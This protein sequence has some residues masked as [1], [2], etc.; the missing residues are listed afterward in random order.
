MPPGM[1]TVVVPPGM[2]TVVMPPG[3]TT[4]PVTMPPGTSATTTPFIDA[5]APVVFSPGNTASGGYGRLA[6]QEDGKQA[7]I[8]V[9][10]DT[11]IVMQLGDSISN[12]VL[13]YVVFSA[14][15]TTLV[16]SAGEAATG[17]RRHDFGV[18]SRLFILDDAPLA[19][20]YDGASVGFTSVG[21][22]YSVSG[23]GL[24]TGQQTY[25]GRLWFSR[26]DGNPLPP[27]LH[28]NLTLTVDNF[29]AATPIL[30]IT[31]FS[32]TNGGFSASNIPIDTASGIFIS[33]DGSTVTF[34]AGRAVDAINA[35]GGGTVFGQFHGE[36]ATGVSG[37][38]HHE[39]NEIFGAFAGTR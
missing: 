21:E 2:T 22:P 34:T 30:S 4:D 33:D 27:R 18:G 29:H 36:D 6:R 7:V 38:I 28:S 35:S 9:S 11:A 37:G 5:G 23:S 19:M 17:G 15:T 1:T 32:G 12:P 25:T 31:P 26:D 10:A 20:G 14:A 8:I 24:P 39:D 13:Q 3:M 16:P